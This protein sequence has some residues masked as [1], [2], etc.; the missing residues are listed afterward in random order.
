MTFGD[1]NLCIDLKAPD[2]TL[3]V[4]WCSPDPVWP[5]CTVCRAAA[6]QLQPATLFSDP[7][8][9]RRGRY[10]RRAAHHR[11]PLACL[12]TYKKRP[13]ERRVLSNHVQ[14][15]LAR[16]PF[17]RAHHFRLANGAENS[18]RLS[19]NFKRAARRVINGVFW[20]SC[21]RGQRTRAVIYIVRL[22]QLAL[23]AKWRVRQKKI[24]AMT[25]KEK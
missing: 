9:S 6:S 1:R 21:S 24:R 19:N 14:R 8:N 3:G 15:L 18:Q 17:V 25:N 11:R 23:C 2:C 7:D 13:S 22:Q 16:Q 5:L 4:K 20:H 10:T 12:S